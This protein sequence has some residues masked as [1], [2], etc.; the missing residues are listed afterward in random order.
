MARNRKRSRGKKPALTRPA[1][2]L[3]PE[4]VAALEGG[5]FRDAIGR[6]K[7][8]GKAEPEGDWR[9]LL[10]QAYLGRAEELSAKHMHKE[11]LAIHEN[12]RHLL[13]AESFHPK[14]I[15]ELLRLGNLQAAGQAMRA[16]CSVVPAPELARLRECFAAHSLADGGELATVLSADDPTVKDFP[17]A[18]DALAAYICADDAAAVLA[19]AAIPFRSPYRDFAHVLKGLMKYPG[20][21]MAARQLLERVDA[22][23]PFSPLAE[24]ALLAL[25]P[26]SEFVDRLISLSPGTRKFAAT[27][28]GW[29][30]ERLD[31]WSSWQRRAAR[32]PRALLSLLERAWAVASQGPMQH[33]LLRLVFADQCDNMFRRNKDLSSLQHALVSAWHAEADGAPW[34][35]LDAWQAVI[36]ELR[37]DAELAPC[38]ETALRVAAVQRHLE[39][40]WRLLEFDDTGVVTETRDA[41]EDSLRLDPHYRPT[42]LVLAEHYRRTNCMKDARRVVDAAESRWPESVPVLG[43]ALNLALAANSFKKAAGI[44]ERILELDPINARARERLV[45]AHLAHARKQVTRAR[46]DLAAKA[47]ASAET[48]A[49]DSGARLQ[50]GLARNCIE[51]FDPREPTRLAAT[52]ALKRTIGALGGGIAAQL[53]LGVESARQDRDVEDVM[54]RL[55]LARV[56]TPDKADLLEFMRQLRLCSELQSHPAASLEP[57]FAPA[58]KRA[59]KLEL[60]RDDVEAV[61]EG[62]QLAQFDT[63]RLAFANAALKRWR[64]APVFEFHAFHA[65]FAD[66]P[67]AAG[68]RHLGRLQDAMDRAHQ[69][70]DMRT[71]HR[72]DKLLSNFAPPMPPELLD[73]DWGEEDFEV[74]GMADMLR[75]VVDELGI[76]GAMNAIA[77][78]AGPG[79]KRNQEPLLDADGLRAL[80]EGVAAD[81]FG[82]RPSRRRHTRR[83]RKPSSEPVSRR[84]KGDPTGTMHDDASPQIFREDDPEQTDL[85]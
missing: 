58:L 20:D 49:S 2:Q 34:D 4:A 14:H 81:E 75:V 24:A 9:A 25:V 83:R 36:D 27:L 55:A 17:L 57:Y 28:R 18:R 84:A 64:G 60:S 40:Q 37:A 5:R 85:F 71:L 47:L 69:E 73:P 80:L 72:I 6:L 26:E 21:P 67:F 70:G 77:G 3:R 10:A 7:A 82:P 23:S 68:E 39:D 44:A 41:L 59:A 30:D 61:C 56:D 51:L 62:L 16:T 22:D 32:G 54:K 19:L 31:A 53:L 63:A 42:Y 65:Q 1:E 78:G 11:A 38:T 8:L 12:R 33:Q 46:A 35:I 74:P 79:N 48:W 29:S 15:V 66:R 13:S 45:N 50:V 76:D 52:D 43:E